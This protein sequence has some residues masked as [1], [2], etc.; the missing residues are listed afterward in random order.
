MVLEP[1]TPERAVGIHF[2]QDGQL[3]ATMAISNKLDDHDLIHMISYSS[4]LLFQ[5]LGAVLSCLWLGAG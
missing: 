2:I 4:A 1:K 3:E 5:M